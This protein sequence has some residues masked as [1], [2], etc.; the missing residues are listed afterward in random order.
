MRNVIGVALG[1]LPE[2]DQWRIRDE[3]KRELEE[4]KAAKM[5]EKLSCYQRM[6]NGVVQKVDTVKASSSKVSTSSLTPKHLV[7]LV[8]VSMVST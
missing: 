3:M 1:D 7:H 2:E 5:H 8:D 4:V 6:R